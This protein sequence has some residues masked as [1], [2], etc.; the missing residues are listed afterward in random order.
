MNY[1]FDAPKRTTLYGRSQKEW[2]GVD[3]LMEGVLQ[4][5]KGFISQR[6]RYKRYLFT[7]KKC[8]INAIIQSKFTCRTGSFPADRITNG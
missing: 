1:T 4:K 2:G 3:S 7:Q 5:R 6:C 8:K